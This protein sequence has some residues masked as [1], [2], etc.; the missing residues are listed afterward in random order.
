MGAPIRWKSL[1]WHF[2]VDLDFCCLSIAFAFTSYLLHWA[3]RQRVDGYEAIVGF[4]LY[5]MPQILGKRNDT[6]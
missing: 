4:I 3:L 5:L 6:S 1:V 2:S